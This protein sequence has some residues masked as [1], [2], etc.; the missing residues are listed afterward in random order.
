MLDATALVSHSMRMPISIMHL[1]YPDVRDVIDT[2][3]LQVWT[4]KNCVVGLE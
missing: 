2:R 3:G 4:L 1:G